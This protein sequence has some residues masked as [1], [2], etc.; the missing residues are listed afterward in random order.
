MT[1]S[2]LI[3]TL[4]VMALVFAAVA[5]L[6]HHAWVKVVRPKRRQPAC[7]ADCGCDH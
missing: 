1:S 2:S 4:I 6:G 3:Q 7:G 5:Y